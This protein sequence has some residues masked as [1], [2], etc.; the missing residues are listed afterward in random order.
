MIQL[1]KRKDGIIVYYRCVYCG[2]EMTVPRRKS[3]KRG[4]GHIKDLWCPW[5]KVDAKFTEIG[6][7]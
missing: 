1:K 4:D 6:I 2:N 3:R 7:W 5:C